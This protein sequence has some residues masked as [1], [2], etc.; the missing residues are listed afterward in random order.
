[1]VQVALLLPNNYRLLSVAAILDVFDTVN[2][3]YEEIIC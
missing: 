2:Q 1:M 3:H